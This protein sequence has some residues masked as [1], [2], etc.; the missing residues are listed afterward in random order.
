MNIYSIYK[1]TCTITGKSYIGFDSHWP[2]RKAEHKSAAKRDTSS[3][4]F[5]NAIRKHG[6]NTF[7]WEVIYQSTE[8]NHCLNQM[9]PVFIKEHST[10]D[11]GYNSTT[12]GEGAYG[13][14][15]SALSKVKRTAAMVEY[16]ASLS[17]EGRSKRSNNC[18]MGQRTRFSKTPETSVTKR[19][20]S[21]SHRGRYEITSPTGQT[22]IANNG[23]TEFSKDFSS[24]IGITYWQL[25]AAYR[26]TTENK[27]SQ[28]KRK[29]SNNWVVRRIYP[30][31]LKNR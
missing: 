5:Y 10:K 4:K 11:E 25:F 15:H 8:G 23:L 28:R 22:F 29:D 13:F 30:E 6:W 12:G 18:S 26:K 31:I 2:K 17:D 19:R 21:E 16:H 14:K 27:K 20:K 9:E 1:A 3:N 24:V 7:V